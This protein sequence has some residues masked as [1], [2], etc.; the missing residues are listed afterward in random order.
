MRSARLALLLLATLLAGTAVQA[1]TLDAWR[2]SGELGERYDGLAVARDTASAA[3]RAMA[4][5]VNAERRR[6]YQ[7]RAGEQRVPAEQVGNVYAREV[8]RGAP[9]GT[10][11][12]AEDGRWQRK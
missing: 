3:A 4:E 6:I 10:W 2:A 9:A 8:F 7:T 5:Q 12:L 1:Q 11:F